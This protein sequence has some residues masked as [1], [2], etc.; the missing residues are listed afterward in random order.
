[1]NP[2]EFARRTG[3]DPIQLPAGESKYE[4]R[5]V[6]SFAMSHRTQ[7]LLKPD[8]DHPAEEYYFAVRIGESMSAGWP[9]EAF[10]IG[11]STHPIMTV[12]DLSHLNVQ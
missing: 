2:L 12:S 3:N 5:E 9:M 8:P 10:N 4:G 11:D 1:M 6:S 7:D